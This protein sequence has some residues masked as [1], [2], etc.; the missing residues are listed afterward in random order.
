MLSVFSH[1]NSYA[2]EVRIP[3]LRI[4]ENLRDKV[5][6]GDAPAVHRTACQILERVKS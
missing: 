1:M 4:L 6:E 2:E 5:H 3:L